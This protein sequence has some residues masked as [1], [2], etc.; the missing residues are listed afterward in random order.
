MDNYS[1]IDY[2]KEEKYKKELTEKAKEFKTCEE[3]EKWKEENKQEKFKAKR[4]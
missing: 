2:Y 3:L 4:C 1:F